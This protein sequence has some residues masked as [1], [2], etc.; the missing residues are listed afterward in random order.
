M[1]YIV[2]QEGIQ[3]EETAYHVVSEAFDEAILAVEELQGEEQAGR[4]GSTSFDTVM[5]SWWCSGVYKEYARTCVCVCV[6][7][8]T[9]LAPSSMI[10]TRVA[11]SFAQKYM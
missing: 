10:R 7:I 11:S 1:K 2:I 6:C 3:G 8:I 9:L 4:V 5:C